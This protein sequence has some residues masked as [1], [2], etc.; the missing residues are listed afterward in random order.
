MRRVWPIV[1]AAASWSGCLYANVRFPRA[2]RSATPAEVKAEA[3]DPVAAGEACSRVVLYLV[4]W[5]DAGYA[6]ATKAALSSAPE[7]VLYD[8]RVDQR[9]RSFVF[10][11]YSKTC[12]IVTAR[13]AKR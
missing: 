4:A 10:G 13:V 8:V 12:T 11:L 3:N 9:V 1:L 6:A 7:G 5:G 2:Y